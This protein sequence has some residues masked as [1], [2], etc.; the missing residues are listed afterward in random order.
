MEKLSIGL[1]G[2]YFPNFAADQYGVYQRAVVTLEALAAQWGF[3]LVAVQTGVQT[4]EQAER[5]RHQLEGAGVDFVLIQ[6]SSFALGDVILPLARMDAPLG[7]WA[8]PEPSLEGEI[9]LNSFTGLNLFTSIVRHHLQERQLPFKWFYG[10]ADDEQF[11]RRPR[12][13]VQALTA[14]KHLRQT[15]IALVGDVAPTFYNL[16]YDPEG[17]EAHLGVQVE[18]CALDEVF[19]RVEGYQARQASAVVAEMTARASEVLVND[20]WMERTGRIVLA[21]RDIAAE[22][23]YGALALRCWPEFQTKL[24]GIG[25]CAAV[26]W[27]NETGLPV[28]CEG[29]VLGTLSMLVLHFVS[30]QPATLMD[31]VAVMEQE[32]L[33]QLWHCGPAPVGLADQAG[34]RLTYHPTLDRASPPDAPRSGVSS[35]L[36]LAPGPATIMRFTPAADQAFLLSA[37][38]VEGPTR[39]YAGSR[40]WLTNLR[41]NGETLGIRDLIETIVYHG[42]PHHYPLARGDWADVLR[43][44]VAWTGIGIVEKVT[45]QD[46]LLSA[47]GAVN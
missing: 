39:G 42:L 38:I 3:D 8:V 22:G 25:P 33:I 35:D 27:L 28:S 6:A 29:D 14:L 47:S 31:L 40:G 41:M 44:L 32:G 11:R 30:G 45:Y 9:P 24:G 10:E 15:R 17:I 5:A 1:V 16:T 26:S 43:E 21:L 34:Q 18:Q 13:T 12:L 2:V 4:A 7:L 20:E 23:K 36:V 37:D 19:R 46:Y